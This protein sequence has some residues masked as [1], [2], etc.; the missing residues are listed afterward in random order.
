MNIPRNA[1]TIQ[2]A[3]TPQKIFAK[4]LEQGDIYLGKYKGSYCITCE[5]YISEGKITKEK[6][7]PFFHSELRE[8]EEPAY[9]LRIS[10]YRS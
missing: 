9:F 6:T 7:C 4:L 3:L 1:T 10:K 8:I 5:D 2:S